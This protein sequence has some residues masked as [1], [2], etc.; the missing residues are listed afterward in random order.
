[1]TYK[2]SA[3][4][5]MESTNAKVRFYILNKPPTAR[6]GYVPKLKK[7]LTEW[8]NGSCSNS[9]HVVSELPYL[10]SFHMTFMLIAAIGL[11]HHRLMVGHGDD[12]NTHLLLGYRSTDE[13][14]G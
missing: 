6:I 13:Q 11:H 14:K 10:I 7:W 5:E 12:L 1:M 4:G 8:R 3:N 9:S 2:E